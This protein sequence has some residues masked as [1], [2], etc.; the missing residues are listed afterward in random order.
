M[1]EH[2]AL[3]RWQNTGDAMEPEDYPRDHRWEFAGGPVVPASAAPAY[4]GGAGCIDPE[5]ALVAAVSSCHMLTFLAIAARK[6]LVVVSYRDQA[7]GHLEKDADGRLAITRIELRPVVEF[8][9]GMQPGAEDLRRLH[10]SAHRN[11]FIAHSIR[12]SVTVA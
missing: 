9:A 6:K 4:K 1:S 10:E 8:A 12:A 11:C 3:V 2:T 5:E 7:V